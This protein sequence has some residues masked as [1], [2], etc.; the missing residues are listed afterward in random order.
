[1]WW[2]MILECPMCLMRHNKICLLLGLVACIHTHTQLSYVF[3]A[4][5][6]IRGILAIIMF[7]YWLICHPTK[8]M[9]CIIWRIWVMQPMIRLFFQESSVT[10]IKYREKCLCQILLRKICS[11]RQPKNKCQENDALLTK[12]WSWHLFFL[13][14]NIFSFWLAIW[15]AELEIYI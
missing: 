6:D 1:M 4:I 12:C 13:K 11:K 2:D 8:P 9:N 14:E 10:P 15:R 7:H 5:A 3:A